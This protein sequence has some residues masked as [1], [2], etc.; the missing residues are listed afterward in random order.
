[1]ITLAKRCHLSQRCVTETPEAE[2]QALVE[3]ALILVLIVIACI[4][5][6]T[7]LGGT[8]YDRYY[9]LLPSLP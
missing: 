9:S 3:Y 8:I 6:L 5:I 1:M 4:S 2:G 7:T